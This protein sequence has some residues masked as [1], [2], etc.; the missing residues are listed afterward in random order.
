MVVTTYHI[1]YTISQLAIVGAT[2]SAVAS[3][4]FSR[5]LPHQWMKMQ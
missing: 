4:V 1:V 2:I 5:L 3:S